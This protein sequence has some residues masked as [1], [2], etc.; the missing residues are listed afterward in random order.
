MNNLLHKSLQL[1]A[2]CSSCVQCTRARTRVRDPCTKQARIILVYDITSHAAHKTHTRTHFC[3]RAR[4]RT[5]TT[6]VYTTFHRGGITYNA[7]TECC[8]EFL[9]YDNVQNVTGGVLL[10]TVLCWLAT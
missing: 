2:V 8:S 6:F 10:V 5:P 1:P 3:I 4:L 7:Q 9:L